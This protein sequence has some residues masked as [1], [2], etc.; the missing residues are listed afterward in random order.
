MQS[1]RSLVM[2][3]NITNRD[4]GNCFEALIVSQNVLAQSL[5]YAR[6]HHTVVVVQIASQFATDIALFSFEFAV[7]KFRCSY[8][9]SL[10]IKYPIPLKIRT[11]RFVNHSII[12]GISVVI[13]A[14]FGK[15]LLVSMLGTKLV[16][17]TKSHMLH[18][19]SCFV[20]LLVF[21]IAITSPKMEL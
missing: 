15:F 1:M 9:Q 12:R 4:I 11:G 6:P 14:I 5:L 17:G 21:D 2:L 19:V 7:V 10:Q 3:S 8:R 16:V 20:N 13:C 18:H